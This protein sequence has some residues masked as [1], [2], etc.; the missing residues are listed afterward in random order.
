[1]WPA[2][3]LKVVLRKYRCVTLTIMLKYL[4]LLMELAEMTRRGML[5]EYMRP[6]LEEEMLHVIATP[7]SMMYHWIKWLQ[8]RP[9]IGNNVDEKWCVRLDIL[10]PN[11]LVPWRNNGQTC[12]ILA[13]YG[14]RTV[15]PNDSKGDRI[16]YFLLAENLRVTMERGGR[17]W[18]IKIDDTAQDVLR[19]MTRGSVMLTGWHRIDISRGHINH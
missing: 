14:F 1:M 6:G 12:H 7:R 5:N 18:L 11:R 15:E 16:V 13:G 3:I 9:M 10:Y 4:W 8:Q 17:N 19:A 2:C